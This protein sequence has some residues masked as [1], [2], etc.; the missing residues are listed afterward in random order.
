MNYPEAQNKNVWAYI[1]KDEPSPQQFSELA[2][3]IKYIYKNDKRNALPIID[4]LPNWAWERHDNRVEGFGYH[5]AALIDEYIKTVHPA[6][7]MNC[8]YPP[9]PDGND[10]PEYYPNLE[11]FR[12]RALQNNIGMMAFV[13]ATELKDI[14]RQPSE[15][16]IRW[17][18]YT[19]L[20]YGA[21]GIWYYN[22]RMEN[23]DYFVGGLVDHNSG[24]PRNEYN[25][26][27]AINAELHA[28]GSVLMKLRS[29]SIMHTGEI[30]P[31]SC[32]RFS[33]NADSGWSAIER[34]KGDNFIIADF[35][36]QDEPLD[37]DAY[38]MLVNKRHGK[39]L[40]SQDSTLISKCE[41]KPS[42]QF[43][44]VYIF[45]YVTGSYNKLSPENSNYII[46]LT[47]GQGVLLKLSKQSL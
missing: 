30:V 21:Q 39:D 45:D 9:L 16:D 28:I 14:Q 26:V 31:D 44:Y 17:Q 3:A 7:L 41:F 25:Q 37:K 34:F 12:E 24:Q 27:K 2:S 8:H 43:K 33:N 32:R 42:R 35:V 47:G 13:L 40:A 15:S 20:A 11:L 18:V 5:Y 23:K 22:Y 36:N 29:T 1:L 6:V 19:S 10:T 38:V 4:M 46:T